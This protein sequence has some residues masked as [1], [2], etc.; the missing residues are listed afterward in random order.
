MF[1][2]LTRMLVPDFVDIVFYVLGAAVYLLTQNRS[3]LIGND[4]Q[5][6]KLSMKERVS[7][8][9]LLSLHLT[10]GGELPYGM[11]KQN[12]PV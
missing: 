5:D 3:K 7:A 1:P 4:K 2:F 11:S 9:D 10:Q 12:N 6:S 8:L